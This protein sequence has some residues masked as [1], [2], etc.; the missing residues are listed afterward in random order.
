MPLRPGRTT[1][2]AR[3]GLG[4]CAK[5]LADLL[6]GPVGA[7][8]TGCTRVMRFQRFRARL[9]YFSRLYGLER[10]AVRSSSLTSF[11][12]IGC[13]PRVAFGMGRAS[14]YIRVD[15]IHAMA[16]K[17]GE[18]GGLIVDPPLEIGAGEWICLFNEP[19]GVTF[20]MIQE[21]THA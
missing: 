16:K 4:A 15:D 3:S 9:T 10:L 19:S 5:I 7:S 17:V 21:A 18:H 12:A 20:A 11:W 2:G 8:S 1:C 6:G 13:G 14:I